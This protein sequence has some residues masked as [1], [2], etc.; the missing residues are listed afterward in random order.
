MDNKI[1]VGGDLKF[2]V[3]PEAD[4]FDKDRDEWEVTI[5]RGSVEHTFSKSELAMETVDQKNNYYVCFS[6][7]EFGAGQYYITVTTHTPDEDFDDGF[8]D[9]PMQYALC[10]VEKL[11]K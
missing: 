10:K 7:E 6:T 1:Y 9:E 2:I 11:K 8:R 3:E 4:G 5:S